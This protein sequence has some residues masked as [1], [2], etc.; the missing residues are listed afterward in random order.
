MQQMGGIMITALKIHPNR[1]PARVKALSFTK[2]LA[3]TF[4]HSAYAIS[5]TSTQRPAT[6][7]DPLSSVV[8]P[9][10][11]AKSPNSRSLPCD[12]HY[13]HNQPFARRDGCHLSIHIFRPV[14]A[15]PSQP[16]SCG[17]LMANQGQD[18]GT[19]VP[20]HYV[21]EL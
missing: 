20:L 2:M 5:K 1:K 12:I 15:S 3:K 17:P 13:D 18:P 9:A 19:W 7:V 6:D 16:S 11:Y 14:R 21:R 8:F 4:D 10:G